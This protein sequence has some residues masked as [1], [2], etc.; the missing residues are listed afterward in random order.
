M[1]STVDPLR[2]GLKISVMSKAKK[3][4]GGGATG[5]GRRNKNKWGG[6]DCAGRF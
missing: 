5:S 3:K 2:R 1:T 4:T 6:K